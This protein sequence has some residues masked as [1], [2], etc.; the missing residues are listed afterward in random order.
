LL[1]QKVAISFG[2]FMFSK[3]H[4]DPPKVAQLAKKS[5]NLVTLDSTGSRCHGQILSLR[6]LTVGDEEKT[7]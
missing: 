1:Q 5:P 4:D 3:N 6:C 2:Y 7:L